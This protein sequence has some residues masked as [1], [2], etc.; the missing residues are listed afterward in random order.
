MGFAK[1]AVDGVAAPLK[2][3]KSNPWTLIGLLAVVL[4]A[5]RFRGQIMN[6]LSKIPVLGTGANKLAGEG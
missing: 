6:A 5:F 2:G 3:I 1:K 4:I